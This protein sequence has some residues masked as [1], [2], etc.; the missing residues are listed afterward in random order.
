MS[1]HSVR[2]PPRHPS[3]IIALAKASLAQEGLE[4]SNWKHTATIPADRMKAVATTCPDG[5]DPKYF[6][7]E[8]TCG[9]DDNRRPKE[10]TQ[11]VASPRAMVLNVMARTQAAPP[12]ELIRLAVETAADAK[13]PYWV[14][15]ANK[16]AVTR[17]VA[18]L[19]RA[20]PVPTQHE[21][22]D[23]LNQSQGG[24]CIWLAVGL[25]KGL[26][27]SPEGFGP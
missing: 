26:D 25:G 11:P 9:D 20:D 19:L 16:A 27:V 22:T 6:Y 10:H 15:P 23:V 4:P 21:V 8:F 18:L 17:S 1:D 5:R 7:V 14:G 2:Q 12:P 24:M 3:E 13:R